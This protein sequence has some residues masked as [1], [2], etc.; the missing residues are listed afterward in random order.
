MLTRLMA[1]SD[2]AEMKKTEPLWVRIMSVAIMKQLPGQNRIRKQRLLF[3]TGKGRLIGFFENNGLNFNVKS[4]RR[5]PAWLRYFQVRLYIIANFTL[6]LKTGITK[7]T[8][9]ELVINRS[10]RE[11][12]EHYGTAIIPARPRAPKDKA[13]VEGTVGVVSTFILAALRNQQFLSLSELNE[14]VWDRLYGFNHKPFQKKN[15][16]RASAFEEEKLFLLPLPGH[17]FELAT[18]R[19]ATV[20][21]NY[22]ISVDTQNYSCPYEYI[23]QKVDV[24]MTRSTVE[25]FFDGNRIASHPRLYGRPNQYC[26]LEAHMPPDH[27]KYIQWNGERFI[28]WAE[29]VGP[30]TTSV[31]RLFLNRYAVEQQGYKSCMALL[32]LTD[33]YPPQRLEAA[34]SKAFSFTASPSLKSIQSILHS[35][36]DKLPEQEVEKSSTSQYGFTRGAGYYDRRD[37]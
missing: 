31:I 19:I 7:N 4:D 18:W 30:N 8:R 12:A 25:I 27:L 14:A 13:A 29:K 26:T 11:M 15:G 16:S 34:C 35:G 1:L 17:P 2:F 6:N 24:R 28:S 3:P 10:Y 36:Q 32:K 21:Y 5:T 33:K 23:K 20:Q 9:D 37:D 22:H